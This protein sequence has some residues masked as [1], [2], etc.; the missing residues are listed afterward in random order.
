M[1]VSASGYC[2]ARVIL[3]VMICVLRQCSVVFASCLSPLC[4]VLLFRDVVLLNDNF[5][6]T[7]P[8]LT[9]TS[10]SMLNGLFF[11]A[12]LFLFLF[13]FLSL[14]MCVLD[15]AV[16]YE[17]VSVRL[18]SCSCLRVYA[19]VLLLLFLFVTFVVLVSYSSVFVSVFEPVF[20]SVVSMF[21]MVLCFVAVS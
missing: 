12:F 19:F 13:L 4:P 6:F 7:L 2:C 3:C 1:S 9:F 5:M 10:N 8:K 14:F 20:V 18:C 15:T 21:C 16:V 11:N 17:P